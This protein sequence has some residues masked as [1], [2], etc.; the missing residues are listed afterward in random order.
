MELRLERFD[1]KRNACICSCSYD[2]SNGSLSYEQVLPL[3]WDSW[4][5]GPKIL[6]L[7]D[8]DN[9]DDSDGNSEV[10]DF[11]HDLLNAINTINDAIVTKNVVPPFSAHA[12]V[13]FGAGAV[14]YLSQLTNEEPNQ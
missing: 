5:D 7:F 14:R 10:L 6:R 11:Q 8:D 4:L 13:G 9:D 1:E 2:P 3:E 12:V